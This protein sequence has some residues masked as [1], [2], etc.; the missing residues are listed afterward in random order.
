MILTSAAYCL[1]LVVYFEARSEPIDGQIAVA[2]VVMNN[3]NVDWNNN[4]VCKQVFRPSYITSLNS[5]QV[6]PHEDNKYWKTAQLVANYVT[7][8]GKK[9]DLTKGA[10]H[11]DM[12][13]S[14]P[15]WKVRC[16][17]TRV[18]KNHFFCKE[19]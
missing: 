2:Q 19:F 18:I 12:I 1:A 8:S 13:T 3:K 9:E 4:R 6:I 7:H 15:Y 10:D 14:K 17:T 5:V 11:F 16:K